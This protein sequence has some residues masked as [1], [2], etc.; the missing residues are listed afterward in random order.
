MLKDLALH[1]VTWKRGGAPDELSDRNSLFMGASACHV[2]ERRRTEKRASG[3]SKK[4]PG[5]CRAE[6]ETFPHQCH[7]RL[8]TAHDDVDS[9][10]GATRTHDLRPKEAPLDGRRSLPQGSR[11]K[12]E[13]ISL[14]DFFKGDPLSHPS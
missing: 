12:G 6:S 1:E 8:A 5:L 7:P 3:D 11:R 14:N 4:E 9:G 13:E 10:G 2:G